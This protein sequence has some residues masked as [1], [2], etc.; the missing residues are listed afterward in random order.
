MSTHEPAAT[1]PAWFSERT[2]LRTCGLDWEYT[3]SYPNM[4][5][6]NCFKNAYAVDEP[7]EFSRL[8]YG[9]EGES[10]LTLFRISGLGRYEVFVETRPSTHCCPTFGF[11]SWQRHECKSIFFLN[12]PGFAVD[13]APVLNM[14]GEC[15]M[16]VN[17]VASR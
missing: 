9:D 12:E 2:K 4:A 6:R 8:T 3:P 11:W 5:A 13:G 1:P 15:V 14:N 10:H 7:V 17:V 16:E